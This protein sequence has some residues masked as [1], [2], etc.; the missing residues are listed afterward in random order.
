MGKN[1]KKSSAREHPKTRKQLRKEKRLMKKSKRNQFYLN[2][3]KIGKVESDVSNDERSANVQKT[4]K[5]QSDNPSSNDS[6]S[7]VDR[8]IKQKQKEIKDFKKLEK[9]MR[10][11]RKRQLVEANEKEDQIIKSLEKKLRLDKR[12]NKSMSK[13]FI[14]EGLDCILLFLLSYVIVIVL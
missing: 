6:T 1:F 7:I 11:Q 12:K 13:S 5:I 8:Q 2:K 9:Q 14:N 3:N 4:K 10:E